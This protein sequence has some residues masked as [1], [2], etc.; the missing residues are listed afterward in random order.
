MQTL[1]H[2][3]A[4]AVLLGWMDGWNVRRASRRPKTKRVVVSVSSVVAILLCWNMNNAGG[5][6]QLLYPSR[7]WFCSF[8][9][10]ALELA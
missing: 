10:E 1:L 5:E 8:S 4:A 6:R 7:F 3:A 2:V 9:V